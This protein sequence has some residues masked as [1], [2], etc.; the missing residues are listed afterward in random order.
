MH[1]PKLSTR[2]LTADFSSFNYR[3]VKTTKLLLSC[4]NLRKDLS[5]RVWAIVKSSP[6]TKTIKGF[7][8]KN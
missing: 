7:P 2:L 5:G 8:K 3:N 4:S 6:K 1:T